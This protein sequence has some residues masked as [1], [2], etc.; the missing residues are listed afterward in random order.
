MLIIYLFESDWFAVFPKLKS[1][2]IGLPIIYDRVEN[3]FLYVI[4]L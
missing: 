4:L 3:L 1:N 2:H